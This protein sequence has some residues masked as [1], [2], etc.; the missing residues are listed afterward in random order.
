MDL[1]RDFREFI[2]LLNA[3]NVSYV[4]AGAYAVAFHGIPRYTKDIDFFV[5]PSPENA[6]RVAGV[7]NQFGFEGL[8]LTA[9]DL[10]KPDQIVQL[11]REPVRIDILTGIEGLTF[12]EAL[13]DSKQIEIEGVTVRFLGRKTLIQNKR[14]VGRSQDIADAARLEELGP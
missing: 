12:A 2:E 11:G 13:A 10:S 7:L 9:E 4:V 8:G 6:R 1:K 14:A 3:A 5:E